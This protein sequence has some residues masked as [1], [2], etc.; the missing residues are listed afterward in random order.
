MNP[1]STTWVIVCGGFHAHGGMDRLN[2][3][4]ARYLV[5]ASVPVH[6]VAHEVERDLIGGAGVPVSIV[7]RT[8]GVYMAGELEL[9]RRAREVARSLRAAGHHVRLVANGA[10]CTHADVNWVHCVHGAWP[11]ADDG[12]P[13]WFRVKNRA[14][15]VWARRRE[16]RAIRTAR[17][18]IANSDR[19]RRDLITLLHCDPA[20][21]HT[22]YPAVD[23]AIRIPDADERAR[24]RARW[25]GDPSRPLVVF[26]GA[27][28]RDANKG[29]DTL[30]QAWERLS[31]GAWDAA[32]VASG[33]GAIAYWSARAERAR[34]AVRFTGHSRSVGEL[35]NAADL[36]VSPSRYEAYGLA[37]HE[38]LA[39]GVPAI[40]SGRAGI[41]ERWPQT[42]RD[43]LLT[44][45]ADADELAR[46]L[47]TWRR[48]ISG[49][50][51]CFVTAAESFRGYTARDMAA[52][53]VQ[54]GA[55]LDPIP[56]LAECP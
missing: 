15:K 43:L 2:A 26:V 48:N 1:R 39:R 17:A 36:L 56:A 19:T 32:L 34:V 45:P 3:A 40:V 20:R 7:P 9:E 49:W 55:A 24:A 27:L 44:D 50:R 10:T 51:A 31:R 12:A 33:G 6:L 5:D 41:A 54:I 37:V 52:H 47:A 13:A 16:R 23:T 46:R 22:V 42:A 38:A 30:L 4:L 28:S 18:V 21:V 8:F 14:L 11:C 35:L 29:F 53:V 25:C